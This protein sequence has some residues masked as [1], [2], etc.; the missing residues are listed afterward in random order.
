MSGV[1]NMSENYIA[2][3]K[4]PSSDGDA[5]NRRYVK[6]KMEGVLTQNGEGHTVVDQ[7]WRLRAPSSDGTWTYLRIEGNAI[8]VYHMADPTEGHHGAN[9]QYVDNS[10]ADGN[11]AGKDVTNTF[12]DVQ[13]FA[14][15]TYFQGALVLNGKNTDTLLEVKGEN[16]NKREMWCK[17][18]GTNKVSWIAYPG[19][20]NRDYKRCMTMEWDSYLGR[21]TVFIDYLSEPTNSRHPTTKKY[22][23]EKIAEAGGGSF[24]E[25]GA[26][27]PELQAGQLFYNTTDKVLYIGE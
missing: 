27:T 12:K 11:F 7:A 15:S 18:R 6:K 3:V 1:L 25:T 23:D 8:G 26:T 14:K 2:N 10:I 13:T 16:E 9:R 19:Q 5:A 17:I 4:D 24:A 22:V 20:E 21:P